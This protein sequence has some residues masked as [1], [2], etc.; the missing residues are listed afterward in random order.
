MKDGLRLMF[1][2]KF[3]KS[4]EMVQGQWEKDSADDFE[5]GVVYFKSYLVEQE[6]EE[7]D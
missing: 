4:G 3:F 2:S 7:T 6:K 1:Y 5:S